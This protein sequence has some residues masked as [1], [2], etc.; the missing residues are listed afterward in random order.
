MT[1]RLRDLLQ[2]AVPED[3]PALDPRE[4]VGAARRARRRNTATLA[5][6]TASIVVG[7][8]VVA[9]ATTGDDEGARV[10]SDGRS[11]T[12]PYDVPT[13]PAK[14]PELVDADHTVESLGGLAAVRLCPDLGATSGPDWEPSVADLALLES[15]DALVH[16]VDSFGRALTTTPAPDPARCATVSVFNTRQSLQLVYEDGRTELVPTPMCGDV[17][18][19]GHILD[20]EQLTR[21][22]LEALDRQRDKLDYRREYDGTLSCE[23]TALGTPARPRREEITSAVHCSPDGAT[24][25]PLD[26]G[27]L[28][29]LNM[30][31]DDPREVRAESDDDSGCTETDEAPYILAATDHGDVLRLGESSCGHLVWQSWTSRT[32]EPGLLVPRRQI[33]IP[34]TRAELGLD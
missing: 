30:A 21:L 18:V 31:W 10:A 25:T 24:T 13:C 6:V 16:D 3:M 2:S 20:G 26:D 15:M 4:V 22:Y 5:G 28:A 12:A 14:L 33:A 23:Q 19:T 17:S 11:T 1:D 29:T 7:V 32:G 9:T 27:Q 34:V 8:A